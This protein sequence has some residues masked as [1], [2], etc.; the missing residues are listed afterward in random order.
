MLTE[1]EKVEVNV[2]PDDVEK[3]FSRG[4]GPGGQHKNKVQTSVFL[5]HIPTGIVVKCEKGRSQSDNEAE[6][7]RLLNE[8]LLKIETDKINSQ[9]T[10][11][12]R[13]QIGHGE[14]SDKRRTYREKDDLVTDHI[15]N[16][17]CRWK[18]IWKGKI[19]LLH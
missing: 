5:K 2:N 18:D 16:K 8:K 13:N 15:T 17:T 10:D 3:W 4:T 1:Q 19:E 7:W 6:A 14:R 9:T 11:N 12:R